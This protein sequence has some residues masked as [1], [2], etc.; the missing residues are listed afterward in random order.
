M[1]RIVRQSVEK[2]SGAAGLYV[3]ISS[4]SV[5]ADVSRPGLDENAPVGLLEDEMVEEITG[6]TYGPLKALCEQ[7]VKEAFS[8]GALVVRPG[9]IVGPHDPTDR[10]TYWPQ[11]VA[12][13]G[14]VLAPGRPERPIRFIDVRDL[15]E[16]IIRMVEKTKPELTMPTDRARQDHAGSTVDQPLGQWEYDVF[17]LGG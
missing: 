11:R 15:A 8:G 3:F 4:L 2:L 5:Y 14:E 9:L 7:A 6:E 1:P 13:G 12:Q 10:F 16:W 17:H